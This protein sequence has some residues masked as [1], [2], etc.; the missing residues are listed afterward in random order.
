MCDLIYYRG[1]NIMNTIVGELG[2]GLVHL[3][4]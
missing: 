4:L 1:S 3:T 2:T